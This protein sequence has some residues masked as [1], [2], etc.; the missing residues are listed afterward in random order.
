LISLLKIIVVF[1]ALAF[2]SY[3]D[4]KTREIDDRVWYTTITVGAVL[5]ALEI[6]TTPSYPL[7][8]L[9]LI[10]GITAVLALVIY[11]IGL[12]GGADAKA[13]LTIAVIMPLPPFTLAATLL[14]FPLIIFGNALILTLLLIPACATWNLVWWMKNKAPFK[15]IRATNI[16]KVA[17][18]FLGVKVKP[19]T[20]KL[21]HFNLMEKISDDGSHYIKLFSR[22]TDEEPKVIDSNSKHIW[23]TPAL[24]LIVFF[25]FGFLFY[26]VAGDVIFRIVLFFMSAIA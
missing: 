23:A 26:F 16:Q 12:Y 8:Q 14:P 1:F 13:L 11:Y 2:A 24:P 25:L 17:T 18:F 5:T 6:L 20:A 21:V 22:L 7:L 15:D 9:G 3:Q 19:E 10:M 4:L